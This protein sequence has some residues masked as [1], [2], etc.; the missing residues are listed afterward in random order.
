MRV[1]CPE[2]ESKFK[3]PD[4]ALG[5]T[6]RKL[7]CSQCAHQW[8]QEPLKAKPERQDT[9]AGK[10]DAQPKG[11]AKGKPK[12]KPKAKPEVVPEPEPPEDLPDSPS[13]DE[14]E[15][16]LG[17]L[18]ARLDYDPPP[19]GVVSRFRGPRPPARSGRRLPVA[20]LVLAAAAVAVPAILFAARGALVEAWPASALLYDTVGL[21]VEVPGEGLV[22]QN[23]YVQRQQEGSIPLLLV[24]GEVRNPTESLRTLP[25]LRGTVLDDQGA[26]LQSWLFTAETTQLL[27]GDV[28]RFQS[29]LPAPDGAASRVNVTFTNERPA[30][31]LGY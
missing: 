10:K 24:A 21:H 25:T 2:C 15:A 13:P 23:V 30:A 18:R 29:E 8:F 31:G 9:P 22:L 28:V 26:A 27:P 16:E 1:T 20:L 3:V 17:G 6:G 5:T 12:P 4:K 14:E 11:K 19:L 7:R